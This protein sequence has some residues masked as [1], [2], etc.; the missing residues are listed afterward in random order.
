[1]RI[2]R[3]GKYVQYFTIIIKKQNLNI[4]TYYKVIWLT[5]QED[6]LKVISKEKL[7]TH[8]ETQHSD[9]LTYHLHFYQKINFK[10]SSYCSTK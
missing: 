1:M 2:E 7:L 3:T 9:I 5:F 10:Y 4:K 8:I 6:L